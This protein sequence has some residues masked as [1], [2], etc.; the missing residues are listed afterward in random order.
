M[1]PTDEQREALRLFGTGDSLAIEAGAGTGKTST[2]VLLAESAGR[3]RGQYV[4]FN[5]AL[6][7]DGKGKFPPSVSANTAH[8]LAFRGLGHKF[9]QRLRSSARM[10]GGDM[11]RRL[12]LDPLAVQDFSGQPRVLMAG[13]LASQCSKAIRSFCQSA[14]QTIAEWHFPYIDGLDPIEG[15]V[16]TYE[17]NRY[18]RRHLLP[19]AREMWDDLQRPHGWV[20]Y[21]HDHYLKAWQLSDP[22]IDVDYVMFDEAQDANPVIAA[23]V[24]AQRHAQLVYVGDSQQEIYSFTGAVNALAQ[25]QVPHRTFLTQ[26]FRFGQA[27]ADEANVILDELNA[28]LRLTGNPAI[29]SRVEP[30]DNP[31]AILTRTNAAGISTLLRLQMEGRKVHMIGGA[32]DVIAFCEAA[33]ELQLTG[34]TGHHELAVFG[35]WADVQVYV[36]QEPEGED[37]RLMVRLIDEF[38]PDAI[39]NGLRWM[40]PEDRAE[41]VISTAHKSKGRQWPTVQLASDFK[42]NK[43]NPG[44]QRLLYVAVTRAQKVLDITA[45]PDEEEESV[46][47]EVEVG[48]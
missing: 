44:E 11:A 29:D 23:I 35:S 7:E 41:I 22:R 24:A 36:E 45:L 1:N 13:F 40:V 30:I 27:V 5:K 19:Y 25:V 31:R 32:A 2:L 14:D 43:D 15:G 4:A 39:I 3:R 37:L 34:R 8:S 28:P 33:R 47:E 12:G 42:R 9:A 38:T 26:S 18:V 46:T 6:V 48:A 20:P 10:T 21:Q 17:I 16:R